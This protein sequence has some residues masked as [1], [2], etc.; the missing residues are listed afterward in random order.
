MKKWTKLFVMLAACIC[1]FG[2]HA[3]AGSVELKANKNVKMTIADTDDQVFTFTMPKDGYFT[4]FAIPEDCTM[5]PQIERLPKECGSILVRM[6]VKGKECEYQ[7]V[8]PENGGWIS[9]RYNFKKGTVVTFFIKGV[10]IGERYASIDY[11]LKVRT[12]KVSLFE[13]ESNDKRK[14]ATPLKLNQTHIGNLQSGTKELL[15]D[16]DYWVFEASR[17]GTYQIKSMLYDSYGTPTFYKTSGDHAFFDVYVNNSKTPLAYKKGGKV[18][19]Q[20][21]CKRMNTIVQRKMKKGEKLYLKLPSQMNANNCFYK[22]KVTK[23]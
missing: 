11:R 9:H 7:Y 15:D 21:D 13:K 6:Q 12:Q 8:H 17:D 3:F 22:L 1:I 20:I 23:K 19:Y 5:M 16:V 10:G 14:T 18:A 4:L 2:A